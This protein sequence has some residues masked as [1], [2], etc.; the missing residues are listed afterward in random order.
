MNL[1]RRCG[2]APLS[3]RCRT[4]WR[5]PRSPAASAAAEHYVGWQ[6]VLATGPVVYL[7]YRSYR[8][9]LNRLEAE[10]KHAEEVASLHLTNY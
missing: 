7:I 1:S 6:T 10:T 4:T 9:Y 3:G 2:C 8:L 5:E